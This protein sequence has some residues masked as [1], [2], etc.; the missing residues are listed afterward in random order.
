MRIHAITI[1]TSNPQRLAAWWS[2]VLGIGIGNDYGRIVQLAAS[3]N[4]LPFQFQKIEDVPTQRNRVHVDLKTTDLD[5]ETERLVG[6]GATVVQKTELPQI[7]Y[8]TLSDPDGNKFDL[9]QDS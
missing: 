8:T 5:G 1:D 6:L 7:R 4:F 2:E 9:V 3:P